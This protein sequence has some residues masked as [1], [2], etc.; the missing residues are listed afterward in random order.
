MD[1]PEIGVFTPQNARDQAMAARLAAF[2]ARESAAFGRDPATG[3]VTG[4]AVVVNPARDKMVLTRHATQGRWLHPGGHCD[5]IRDPRFVALKEAYEKS[6]LPRIDP[7]GSDILDIDIH[8]S[9]ACGAD[10]AHL[11]YDLR[12]VFIAAES[13]PRA[14]AES[15]ALAWVPL[16]R[17]QDYSDDASVLVL[18]DKLARI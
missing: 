3:H 6:G 15:T 8:E 1:L 12:Y 11:H 4:S 7:L 14:L 13:P 17:L 18:R 5:G 9:P 2:L 10:P 16:A